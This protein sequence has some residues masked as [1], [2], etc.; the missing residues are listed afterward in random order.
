LFILSFPSYKYH[1]INVRVQTTND[2]LKVPVPNQLTPPRTA[3]TQDTATR[4]GGSGGTHGGHSRPPIFFKILYTMYCMLLNW[5]NFFE[6]SNHNKIHSNNN[7]K[8]YPIY[9]HT[10]Q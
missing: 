8:F 1:Y 3:P 5:F 7:I 4:G 2:Q 6:F 10:I 9:S